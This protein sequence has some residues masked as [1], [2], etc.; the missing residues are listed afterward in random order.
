MPTTKRKG[1]SKRTRFSVFDRDGFTCVY[2]GRQPPMVVLEIEHVI[3]ASKG[4]EDGEDNLRTSCHECNAGKGA[5]MIGDSV[6][7]ESDR[8]RQAQELAESQMRAKNLLKMQKANAKISQAICNRWAELL[9]VDRIPNSDISCIKHM[10]EEFGEVRVDAW[11]ER[12]AQKTRSQ[13]QAIRYLCGI[14]R[15]VRETNQPQSEDG[16]RK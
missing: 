6:P 7:T 8:F 15:R 16:V 3:P 4:G 13:L 12:A 1:I 14:A 9:S 11:M 2:C 5:K 10:M